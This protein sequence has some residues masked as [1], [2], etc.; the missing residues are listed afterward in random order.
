MKNDY[1]KILKVNEDHILNKSLIK[2]SKNNNN[3]YEILTIKRSNG[4]SRNQNEKL[5]TNTKSQG[6]PKNKDFPKINDK[7]NNL[8][9]N[10]N[11]VKSIDKNS[12]N[13]NNKKNNMNSTL[14]FLGVQKNNLSKKECTGNPSISENK[15]FNKSLHTPFLG[16]SSYELM[17]PDWQ[18]KKKI[19]ETVES[20]FMENKVP[21]NGRS[22]YQD[23]F[24]NHEKR[25]YVE[26]TSPI[27]KS[28]NLENSGKL[29]METTSNHT[30]K[31]ID[32]KK[33]NRLNEKEINMFKRP[34]SILFAPFTKDSFLSSYEKAFMYNN[35]K[36]K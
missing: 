3:Y 4:N 25:Y 12:I 5:S 23:N 6:N 26:R 7:N 28:D 15:D 10:D 18:T 27:Y 33:Y 36:T 32:Y 16:R 20:K 11:S 9:K 35:F 31:Q 13:E 22:N 19:K 21:F 8:L 30:Y 24:L 2:K 34:A 29:H 14:N 17:Y 1:S